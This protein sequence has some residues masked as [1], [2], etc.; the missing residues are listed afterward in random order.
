MRRLIHSKGFKIFC[1]VI[2]ALLAGSVASAVS[3]SNSA[4]STSAAGFV[5]GPLQRVSS[6]LTQ[7]VSD[8]SVNFKSSATLRK[9]IE[10]L[11]KIIAQQKIDLVDYEKA[12]YKIA[13][14]EE[15]LEVKEENPDFKFVSASVIAREA[16]D[17][18]AGMTLN[19][20]S[21]KG[22]S[23]NDPVIFGKNLV[24]LV[25]GVT[26]TQCEVK[27][28]LNPSV[29][30]SAYE[31]KTREKGVVETNA[32]LSREG[33]CRLTNLSGSTAVVEGGIVCTS[34]I[35]GIFPRDLIIGTV[36]R[37][38]PRSGTS[39]VDAVVKPDA[40]IGGLTDVF[41]I[42]SFEGQQSPAESGD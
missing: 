2:A 29:S 40:D 41:I 24:G 17:N 34:G 39:S 8:F 18:Y 5:F 35:G 7:Q 16:G 14:Y 33:F 37:I 21:V 26:P 15:F 27:T 22:V 4:L 11:N 20:G 13:V 6:F 32:Q 1:A 23:V 9:Q 42:T 10:E 19:R 28:L 25:V 3:N 30:V 12:K 36:Q 31:I 38:V